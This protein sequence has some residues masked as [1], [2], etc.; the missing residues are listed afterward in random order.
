MKDD[1]DE[2]LA[3]RFNSL[4]Q[5]YKELTK[6]LDLNLGI[7]DTHPGRKAWEKIQREMSKDKRNFEWC[8]SANYIADIAF[9]TSDELG[10]YL[11]VEIN[12]GK[13]KVT[14]V[15]LTT[16]K[17]IDGFETILDPIEFSEIVCHHMLTP[18]KD[19]KVLCMEKDRDLADFQLKYW[20]FL[21][22]QGIHLAM[23]IP[24]PEKMSTEMK[25]LLALL[26]E[27]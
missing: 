15:K 20:Y 19:R 17:D 27:S 23:V 3:T 4:V 9:G 5:I 26:I 7:M 18:L 6:F 2:E 16:R 12:D 10:Y 22:S 11:V 25:D 14:S 24:F 13:E 1:F 21:V 8:Q